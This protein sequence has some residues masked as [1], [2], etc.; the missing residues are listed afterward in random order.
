M[1]TV[2]SLS[3]SYAPGATISRLNKGLR[4]RKE[5]SIFGFGIDP[6]TGRWT[7]SP[8]EGR[9]RRRPGRAGKAAGRSDRPGPQERTARARCRASGFPSKAWRRC[10]TRSRAGSKSSS[11]SKKARSQ[12][13]PVPSR[14][15]RRGIL[16][17]EAT[18]GGAGVLGRLTSDAAA[19]S[20]SVARAALDLMHYR[21]LDAAIAAADP[22]L[23]VAKVRTPIASRAATA[24]CCPTTI[25]RIT[26]MIDRT[27][28]DGAIGCCCGWP[29]VR[30]RSAK[31]AG[32]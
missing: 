11:S 15:N 18:E 9:R 21:D 27:D 12:T 26:S 22:A 29:A 10:S 13:E 7:G 14:E 28:D 25:S 5:K 32:E 16:A 8:V 30:L 6:A 3:L 1:P 23:L 4:R 17:F 20:R 2:R 31:P 24:A 19:R